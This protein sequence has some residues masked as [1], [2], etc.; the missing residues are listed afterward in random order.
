MAAFPDAAGLACYQ[1]YF[2]VWPKSSDMDEWSLSAVLNSP[3]A[4]AFVATREGKTDITKETLVLVP[5]PVFTEAQRNALRGLI[6]RYQERT[7]GLRGAATALNATDD[8]EAL[9]KQ[10]DALVL[11]AYKMPPRIERQLLDFF[12]GWE[13][14][15]KHSFSQ[16]FPSDFSVYFSLS[17]Y[18]SPNFASATVGELLKRMGETRAR[19]WLFNGHESRNRMG[20]AKLGSHCQAKCSPEKYRGLHL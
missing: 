17:D 18:L 11:S 9:L 14:P 12:N 10:I 13:R 20:G 5:V 4:N 16:Y 2:G 8:A 1:T 7:S 6:K 19:E 3:V 15:V